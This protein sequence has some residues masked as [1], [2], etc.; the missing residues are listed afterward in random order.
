MGDE[1][2]TDPGLIAELERLRRR[3]AELERREAERLEALG[4]LAAGLAHD[5]NNVLAVIAGNLSLAR[6]LVAP[7]SEV[8]TVLGDGETAAQRGREITRQLLAFA[9]GDAPVRRRVSVAKVVGEAVGL[10]LGGSNVEGRLRLPDGLW[11]VLADEGQLAQAFDGLL[12]HARQ[13][14]PG[15]GVVEVAAEN[16]VVADRPGPP[17]PG[18]Y[19]EVTVADRG[20]GIPQ[21]DVPRV[22]DP[23]FSVRPGGAGLGLATAHAIVRRHGGHI[24]V[25]SEEGAVTRFRVYLPAAE[26]EADE[27]G[28]PEGAAGGGEGGAP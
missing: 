8:A 15:G 7:D 17:R 16:A 4:R 3:V 20:A 24:D 6:A 23:F 12:L 22:F 21:A 13:A 9:R 2:K 10:A 27:P 14:M 19:V 1:A 11:P 26:D 5:F 28:A 18:R 25:E